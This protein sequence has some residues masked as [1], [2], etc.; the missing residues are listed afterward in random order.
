MNEWFYDWIRCR[1]LFPKRSVIVTN[2]RTFPMFV[3]MCK[4]AHLNDV[5]Y[6]SISASK[7][8]ALE[9]F[10][11]MSEVD[12]YLPDADNVL[13]LN[14]DDI[15]EDFTFKNVF[16]EDV[17]YHAMSEEQAQQTIEF[18]EKNKINNI[19][20]HCRAGQSRSQA[21]CRA[22]YDCYGDVY[23]PNRFNTYN[24]CETP[25]PDVLAK[26]KRAYYEKYGLFQEN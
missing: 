2:R 22:I 21:I 23:E 16:G 20:I 26:V 6:I 3:D 9:H 1:N 8:C 5:A 19:I 11:D 24:P 4:A 25:N 17:T 10:Y 12:H 13:N 7:E 18:I 15:T 14:F